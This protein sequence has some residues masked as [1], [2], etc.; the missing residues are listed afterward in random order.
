MQNIIRVSVEAGLLL[1]ALGGVLWATGRPF[2][3]PSL[4]PT[5]FLLAL[6]PGT[7]SAREV[8]G[9]H[10]CGVLGGLS[11][12][13]LLADGLVLTSPPPAGSWPAARLAGSAA[14]S[15]ALTTVGMLLTRTVHAPACATTLIVSLGLLSTLRDGLVIIVA[16]MILFGLHRAA[17]S[18]SA[19]TWDRGAPRFGEEE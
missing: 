1:G 11:A 15:V 9:G 10:L 17:W 7:Q 4:G 2:V 18:L 19:G 6:R 16:V 14:L 3:F 13:V 5:A 12:Y 8:I